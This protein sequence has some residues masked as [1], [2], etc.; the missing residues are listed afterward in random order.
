MKFLRIA[1]FIPLFLF[2]FPSPSMPVRQAFGGG[3]GGTSLNVPIED[4]VY[5]DIDVLIAHGLVNDVVIGQRPYSRLEVARIISEARANFHPTDVT[6]ATG[7]E[8]AA[9]LIGRGRYIEK[10]LSFYEK[11]YGEACHPHEGGVIPAGVS[12][13]LEYSNS[14]DSR[15]CGNDK[16]TG[17][18]RINF[19][20]KL[21]F[22]TVYNSSAPRNVPTNNGVGRIN[23]MATSFD[24]NQQGVTYQD[25]FN[26]LIRTAHDL[27]ITKYAAATLE[28]LF[29]FAP[30]DAHA[31]IQRLYAKGG[32]ENIELEVGRD[33]LL[34][35][36]GEFGGLILAATARP[37]DMI[38]LSNTH[39][40][41]G[42]KATF[43]VSTLGPEREF[44]WTYLYGG[45]FSIRPC[46]LF[47]VGISEAILMGGD[48][49]PSVN[50]WE[51][52]TELIPTRKTNNDSH[53]FG[54]LDMRFTIPPLRNSVIYY[55]G[56]IEQS[57]L[58]AFEHLG[59]LLDQTAFTWGFYVPRLVDRGSTSL[60]IEYQHAT[61]IT[62]RS[63]VWTDGWTLDRRLLGNPLG[64]DADAVHATLYW[65]PYPTY[66]ARLDLAFE[67][68]Y[69]NTYTWNDN[70]V[71]KAA[72]GVTESRYRVVGGLDLFRNK[73][74]QLELAA[75]YERIED[76][77]FTSG[78]GVN[79][80]LLLGRFK[81][82]F[83]E[84]VVNSR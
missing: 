75:G 28:P 12:G 80:M 72:S 58:R 35:G 25:G 67:N 61:P 71:Q 40:W 65:R 11:E 32:W 59:N 7:F 20:R 24:Q 47:E 79:N 5:L 66:G 45:K 38:K 42:M 30:D 78:K 23:A 1:I 56:R 63:Q 9:K 18:S 70:E 14:R 10:L 41:H 51:P 81:F 84:F 49:A 74:L 83:D 19:L 50:W 34:F 6:Q 16:L 31:Y 69:S 55:D 43:F 53:A 17:G 68:Y 36:Q 82:N 46:S 22:D 64:S 54:I 76:W 48:G 62:A 57:V 73:R 77:N 15:S 60:R 27:Y 37:L 29:E 26:Y 39:P 13:Y 3:E 33:N 2:L 8:D 21:E 4:P 44:P 52:I